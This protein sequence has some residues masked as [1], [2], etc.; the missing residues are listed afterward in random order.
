[1]I[2]RIAVV[3]LE[4][5]LALVVGVVLAGSVLAWRLS[6][7]PIILDG[8]R[9]YVEAMLSPPGAALRAEVGGTE[10]SWRGWDRALEVVARD[11]AVLEPD[12]AVRVRVG[13]VA[14]ALSPKAL[15]AGRLAP[16]R[17]NV[18]DPRITVARTG[19]GGWRLMPE[20]DDTGGDFDLAGL[21]RSFADAEP[22]G[23]LSDLLEIDVSGA[24]IRLVD[25]QRGVTLAAEGVSAALRRTALGLTFNGRG[26]LSWDGGVRTPV[27]LHGDYRRGDGVV[28]VEA[29]TSRVPIDALASLHPSL[30]ALAGIKLPVGGVVRAAAGLDGK[31][32][33]GSAELTVGA[34]SVAVVGLMDRPVEIAGATVGLAVAPDLDAAE[35]T[36]AIDLSGPTLTLTSTAV[37]SGTGYSVTLDGAAEDLPVDDLE[38]FWPESVG[39][40]AREWVT[41][42]LRDGVVPR[43]S[44]RAE[45]WLDPVDP[46]TFRLDDLG[47]RID[48]SGVTAHYFR[49]LPP[50]DGIVGTALYDA[51]SFDISVTDGRL[52]RLKLDPSR[53]RIRGMVAADEFAEIEVAV[54]GP[55]RDALR[56]I[57]HDPLGYPKELG[58]DVATVGGKAGARLRFDFPLLKDLKLDQVKLAVSANLSDV[59]LPGVVAGET[60]ADADLKV[61]LDGAGMTVSGTGMV[62]GARSEV[63]LDQRFH[64]R[65]PYTS[66]GRIITTATRDSLA[67]FGLDLGAMMGGRMAVD[68]QS[69]TRAD[70]VETVRLTADLQN[71]WLRV[72]ELGWPKPAGASGILRAR[73]TVRDGVPVSVDEF[74]MKAGAMAVQAAAALGDGGRPRTVDLARIRIGRTD[75]AGRVERLP[76]GEWR[77]AL[78]GPTID[79]SPVLDPE[80]P[81]TEDEND[82]ALDLRLA[83]DTLI[84]TRKASIVAATLAVRQAGDR[85]VSLDL[86][87]RVGE[88]LATLAVLPVDGQR[89]LTLRAEDAGEFLAAFDIVETIRGGRLAV[90]GTVTGQG[91]DDGMEVTARIDEFRVVNAPVLARVLSVAS[92][93]GLADVLRGEGIRFS[94]ARVGVTLTSDRIEARNGLAYGPG[95]G[96]KVEGAYDRSSDLIDFVGMVAPAYSLSRLIDRIPVFGELL[97]GGEGEG[98]LATEFR[99]RGTMDDPAVTV[100]PLT[101]LAPGFLRDLLSTA[102]SPADAPVVEAPALSAP[103]PGVREDRGR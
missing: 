7:G 39:P 47:G 9:P 96:L 40:P 22:G 54:R 82:L 59:L 61:E 49:P 75:A 42:N 77:I 41:R 5:A 88:G 99:V 92:F 78:R 81:E 4:I 25:G 100:N 30:T 15:I 70:G 97:T 32:L 94:R 84:V 21:L 95:L 11:V 87:G 58:L 65:G 86:R 36:A 74:D 6:E 38:R 66:R 76:S 2:H 93:T 23:P 28:R 83:A 91:L 73:L 71:A 63:S 51:D 53:V 56:V 44:V 27:D 46:G 68:A 26:T 34:G 45:A 31:G 12:G 8:L 24:R 103:G 20:S 50:I 16:R 3:C 17:I 80:D 13:S 29:R 101:A 18:L 85:L 10:I 72:D 69:E 19:D 37:R 89:R 43:A 48:F 90:D 57:D 64:T 1:M 62:L 67:A 52:D 79:L 102:E 55:L 60:L 98:L 33:T 35:L 14:V